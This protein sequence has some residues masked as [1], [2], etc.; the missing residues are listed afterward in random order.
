MH[1]VHQRCNYA[2]FSLSFCCNSANDRLSAQYLAISQSAKME[3]GRTYMTPKVKTPKTPP[4]PTNSPQSVQPWVHLPVRYILLNT[5]P[6]PTITTVTTAF[7]NNVL[8]STPA[9]FLACKKA[10][11]IL[12]T[13]PAQL[14]P[15]NAVSLLTLPLAL[16]S[17]PTNTAEE[18]TIHLA[19][20]LIC[21]GVA[22]A[23]W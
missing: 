18:A 13:I 6:Q 4:I 19:C 10:Y 2:V 21:L 12:T 1:V 3:Y 8:T 5:D 17:V 16:Y 7:G 14:A 11:A 15:I 20:T 23:P 9:C 22:V